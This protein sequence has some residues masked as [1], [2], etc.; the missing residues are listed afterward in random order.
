MAK[1]NTRHAATDLR[2]PKAVRKPARPSAPKSI[3]FPINKLPAE[4]VHMIC[5]YLK[6]TEI[7][8]LRLVSRL[9][10]PIG[11]QY[12]VPEVHLILAK[13]SFEQLKTLAEHP[14]ASKYVTS[15]FFE[16]DKLG[17]LLR[18]RWEHVVAGPQFIAQ[19]EELHMRGHPCPHAS[20][21]SVR[22]FNREVSKMSAAPRHHY[23]EEQM[24]HAFE[25]YCDFTYFQQGSEEAAVQ[26]KEVCCARIRTS[27]LRKTFEPAF[28]TCYEIDNPRNT[29]L[30]PLGLRQMRSLL[31]GA[32]HAGLKVEALH[33]GVVSWR[34][35]KQ[36]TETFARMRNSV[37]NVKNLRLE[38]TTGLGKDDDYSFEELEIES[39]ASYLEAGRLRDF[40]TAAPNLEHLRIGFQF[41][42]PIW[43]TQ[44][45]YIVG[46]HHWPSLKTVE[47]IKIATSEDELVSFCSRHASTLKS[48]YLSS[49]GLLEGDWFSAFNKMR[50]ILTLDSMVVLGR[51]EG[52]DEGLDFE[53]GSE[54]YCPELKEGIEAYFMGPC[55]SDESSLDEFLDFY[56]PNSDDTWS[57]WD[58][59]DGWW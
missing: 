42:E 3:D 33:C 54:E 59:S 49:I 15:F 30:E 44:L 4:L 12:M 14:I 2:R 57:E 8:N 55:S 58:S 39:C 46:E 19:V 7:A 24:D 45:E 1:N 22:T 17:L 37:S 31:L 34:I 38:F 5:V 16:A 6:P 23:T 28:C 51:L 53:M 27:R 25:N 43:P 29:K 32:Y 26:E 18:K 52:L 56:L 50:K 9:A 13:D 41:N 10:A 47:L 36:D 11:L 35:L 48:L 40:V 21:R 20:E